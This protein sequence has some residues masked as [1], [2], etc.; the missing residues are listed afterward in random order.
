MFVV[1][2]RTCDVIAESR[3]AWVQNRPEM[4][5]YQVRSVVT[6]HIGRA[7][8]R[9]VSENVLAVGRAE[10]FNVE[11]DELD[12]RGDVSE[13]VKGGAPVDIGGDV[14]ELQRVRV[15]EVDGVADFSAQKEWGDIPEG[16]RQLQR[17]ANEVV[18]ADWD[19]LNGVGELVALGACVDIGR[20]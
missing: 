20:D 7:R 6:R 18:F 17:D 2:V 9:D 14:S 12:K 3:V 5:A 8:D 16:P 1:E 11:D 4:R 10:G 13:G 15:H 19:K